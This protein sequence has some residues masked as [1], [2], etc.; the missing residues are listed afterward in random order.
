[1]GFAQNGLPRAVQLAAPLYRDDLVLRAARAI[2][3]AA[4][5]AMP[6]L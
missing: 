1:M 5:F 2:E 3:V 6:A 4:P